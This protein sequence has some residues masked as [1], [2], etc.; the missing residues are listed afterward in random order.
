M[1]TTIDIP[2]SLLEETLRR[3]RARTKRDAVVSALEQFN[4]LQRLRELN[5]RLKGTMVRFMTQDDL[6]KMRQDAAWERWN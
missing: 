1:K 2:E 4:R 3:T 5:G 6:K